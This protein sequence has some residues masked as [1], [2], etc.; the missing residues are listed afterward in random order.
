MTGLRTLVHSLITD[1]EFRLRDGLENTD[2]FPF[3]SY[4]RYAAM[5]CASDDGTGAVEG[6]RV[7]RDNRS[8]CL[9]TFYPAKPC[10]VGNFIQG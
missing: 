2:P 9:L 5:V 8:E 1:P 3:R 10:R 4:C 7:G 6:G